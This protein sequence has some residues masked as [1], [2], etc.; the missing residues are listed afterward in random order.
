MLCLGKEEAQHLGQEVVH[1][2]ADRLPLQARPRHLRTLDLRV[3]TPVRT[4]REKLAE[5]ITEAILEKLA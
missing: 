4:P 3:A 5:S 2:V 1:H